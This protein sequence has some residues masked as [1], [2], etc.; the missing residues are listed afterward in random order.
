MNATDS[1]NSK[2]NLKGLAVGNGCTGTEIGICSSN[3][4]MSIKPMADFF[5]FPWHGE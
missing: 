5:L 2:I 3:I 4:L 1:G